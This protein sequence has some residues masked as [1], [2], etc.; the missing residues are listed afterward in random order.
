MKL[1]NILS[2]V[3]TIAGTINP[4]VGT[5]ISI[6][7]GFLPKE[8]QLPIEATGADVIAAHSTLAPEQQ[9]I[10]DDSMYQYKLDMEQEY[11]KQWEVMNVS[12]ASGASTRPQI[13]LQMSR[14]L[15]FEIL[16][17]TVY[18]FVILSLEGV[19]GLAGLEAL[20]VVFG[21][22]TATPATLILGYFNSRS[23]EKKTRYA[24]AGG[25]QPITGVLTNLIRA[26]KS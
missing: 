6:V 17:F 22:L 12:D 18:M 4:L 19:A 24:I 21:I 23:N 20:W 1:R 11:T 26:F 2:K 16:A 5:G 14:V 8:K 3:A 10:A 9:A 7:N 15:I 25:Q 13:A